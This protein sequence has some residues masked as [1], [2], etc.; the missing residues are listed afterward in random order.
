M[1]YS[2]R[3][4]ILFFIGIFV[5]G[6]VGVVS[7]YVRTHYS[8]SGSLIAPTANADVNATT[9]DLTIYTQAQCDNYYDPGGCFPAGTP[10]STPSG[11]KEIQ[12][13]V[14]GDLVYGYDIETGKNVTAAVIETMKHDWNEVHNRSP[15][16][17]ITHNKGVVI[18]TANHWVYRRNG[19]V[20]E[21]ANFD[22]AGMLEAGDVLTLENG[23]EAAITKI[24]KGPEYDFVYNLGVENVHTYFASGIRVH[25]DGGDCS[26]D[27]CGGCGSDGGSK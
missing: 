5:T 6:L 12:S 7:N 9:C 17:I 16:L 3:K 23:E 10:I 18:L 8:K 13:L 22:R 25:N 20:G 14:V 27:G 24:D 4:R 1:V 11:D 2:I 26:G 21:Y 19:R 15:L